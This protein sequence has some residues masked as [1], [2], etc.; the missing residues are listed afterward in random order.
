CW[1]YA[2]RLYRL[3]PESS[4]E[5]ALERNTLEALDA[6]PLACMRRFANRSTM[7]AYCKGLTGS[8]AVWAAHKYPGHRTVP[9]RIMD[10]MEEA[11]V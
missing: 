10:D 7:D 9:D 5:D 2:K 3:N 4:R 8:Q 11:G 1:G 6:V